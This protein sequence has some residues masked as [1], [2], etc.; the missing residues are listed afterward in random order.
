MKPSVAAADKTSLFCTLRRM[1]RE[2]VLS[3]EATHASSP[4]FA[5]ASTDHRVP[6][7]S[8]SDAQLRARTARLNASSARR[9]Q[10]NVMHAASVDRSVLV[11][12]VCDTFGGG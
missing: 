7:L 1:T 2:S 9:Y 3:T 11:A 8:A 12:S 4:W 10:A 5:T 6:A